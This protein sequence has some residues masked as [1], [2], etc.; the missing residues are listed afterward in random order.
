MDKGKRKLTL[1]KPKIVIRK[2]LTIPLCVTCWDETNRPIKCRSCQTIICENCLIQN[3]SVNKLFPACVKCQNIFDEIFLREVLPATKITFLRK[4]I[5][6]VLLDRE[7]SKFPSDMDIIQRAQEYEDE[8]KALEKNSDHKELFQISLI[9][10]EELANCMRI[11]KNLSADS[12]TTAYQLAFDNYEAAIKFRNEAYRASSTAREVYNQKLSEFKQK[13]HKLEKSTTDIIPCGFNDCQG[14]LSKRWKCLLC[15]TKKCPKC[16]EFKTKGHQCDKETVASVKLYMQDTKACPKCGFRIGRVSGCDHMWCEVCKTS[17]DYEKGTIAAYFSNPHFIEYMM[18]MKRTGQP[19]I[20]NENNNDDDNRVT[21][22]TQK[23]CFELIKLGYEVSEM[24][25]ILSF[26]DLI[27][28]MSDESHDLIDCTTARQDFLRGKINEKQ[29]ENAAFAAYRKNEK[30]HHSWK[31]EKSFRVAGR[32]ALN[33]LL[34]ERCTLNIIYDLIEYINESFA[35]IYTK[36]GYKVYPYISKSFIFHKKGS[37]AEK[38]KYH[39]SKDNEIYAKTQLAIYQS[40]SSHVDGEECDDDIIDNNIY[41]YF[42]QEGK[43]MKKLKL[44]H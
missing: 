10:T 19:L 2:T 44:T 40:N 38:E 21:R 16:H 35:D 32:Q 42:I 11:C 5:R 24:A 37:P 23:I 22:V 33:E 8:L 20:F 12:N 4:F 34:K 15:F 28:N 9:A 1:I 17:F 25:I 36:L 18:N 31:I 26:R 7:K 41:H 29:L 27:N 3:M 30:N 43:L 14:F 39:S 13:S 6:A